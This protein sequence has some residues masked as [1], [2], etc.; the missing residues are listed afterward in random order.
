MKIHEIIQESASYQRYAHKYDKPLY[1]YRDFI[2]KHIISKF[3]K[4][5][6]IEEVACYYFGIVNLKGEV[7]FISFLCYL[8]RNTT[9]KIPVTDG[10]LTPEFWSKWRDN[11]LLAVMDQ[12]KLFGIG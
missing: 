10:I 6:S 2:P 5:A 4:Q 11:N 3:Y 1:E 7:Q 8:E 12:G 9:F